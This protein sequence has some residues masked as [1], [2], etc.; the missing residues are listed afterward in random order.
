MSQYS[1]FKVNLNNNNSTWTK[2]FN[3]IDSES[4]ILDIGCSSGYFDKE[5]ISKKKCIVDGFELDKKDAEA[6]K[7]ICRTVRND[8]IENYIFPKSDEKKYDYILFLD[9]LEHLVDPTSVLEKC[10]K[11]LR[12]NGQIIFSIPNMAH[13][14]IRLEMLNGTFSYEDEGLLDRTHLH[15]YDKRGIVEL[16]NNAGYKFERLQHVIRDIPKKDIDKLLFH[17]GLK[18]TNKFYKFL[19]TE[20][21]TTYQYVASISIGKSDVL[22]KERI[23][24]KALNMYEDQIKDIQAEV[25]K[26]LSLYKKTMAENHRLTIEN[27]RLK[28]IDVLKLHK[29]VA[30]IKSKNE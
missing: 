13:S 3:M 11:V 12:R 5:L 10:K 2:V 29:V 18:A 17:P 19:L 22:P 15:F 24:T 1:N 26:Y 25:R 21:A 4:I 6:A 16:V 7:N 27:S 28:K 14:S 9:V 23:N 30:K 8:N 20:E